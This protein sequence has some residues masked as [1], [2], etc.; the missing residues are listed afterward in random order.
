MSFV[1]RLLPLVRIVTVVVALA[2]VILLL[3]PSG[4]RAESRKIRFALVQYND[5]P[6]S[7]MT[8]DGLLA[9][10]AAEGYVN[11]RNCMISL[12]NA[13]GD[14]A[15]VN[16]M[17]DAVAS[18][19]PDLLFV[20]S[21]PTLQSAVKKIKNIPVVFASVAD[22][23]IAGAGT[24]FTDHVP[25]VTGI[26]T[27]GDY[28]GMIDMLNRLL[29]HAVRIGTLFTPGESNS[30][31]NVEV[32]SQL[33]KKEGK[34]LITV[35]VNSSP[36]IPDACQALAGKQPEVICQVID[37]LI[38]SSSAT[39]IRI[40]TENKIPVFGFVSDQI[41]HGAVIA[42]ARDYYQAGF[43]AVKMAKRILNGTPPAEIP[44]EYVSKTNIIIN[45][46]AASKYRIQ[47]PKEMMADTNIRK[48]K[49]ANKPMP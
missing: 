16:L 3:D 2:A 20:T 13:Q 34:E 44:F 22:P 6:L 45:P 47:I 49:T 7:E 32:F 9:G 27:M 14:V 38:S 26:S 33:L 12:S 46:E 18:D 10:L 25:N 15:M 24:S 17:V 21:T 4:R 42:L 48:A 35:P 11:G 19:P 30:A 41:D 31:H 8:R 1:R 29:P 40:A 28:A 23:V 37:N 36:E 39:V 5:A 43:D